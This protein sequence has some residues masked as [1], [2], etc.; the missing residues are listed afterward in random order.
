[1]AKKSFQIELPDAERR[2][3]G[4]HIEQDF[5]LAKASHLEWSERCATFM[6]KWEAR[7]EKTKAGDEGKPNHRVPLVQ[8]QCFN[9]WAR[10]AQALL[11]DDAEVTAEGTTPTDRAQCVKIGRY[12]T[13]RLFSQ[14]KIIN[15]LLEF[16]FR[17]LLN[18][19]SAAYRPWYRHTFDTIENGKRVEAC[20]YEGPGFFPLEPD[21]L[22][23]PPERGVRSLQDFSFVIRRYPATVDEIIRGDGTLYQGTSEPE[24]AQKLVDWA[25]NNTSNDYTLAGMDP[26]RAEREKSE[27]VDY[28]AYMLSRRT[29]WVWEW[30]GKWRPLKGTADAGIDDLKGREVLESD[31]VVRYIPGLNEVVGVQD[32]L[33]LYPKMARRR[34]FVESTL[35]KDGTYRGKGFGALLGDLEDDLTANSRLFTAAGELSVWPIV[36]FKPGAG[37]KPGMFQLEPGMAIPTEDPQGVNVVRITPNLE[38]AQARQQDIVAQGER[39]TGITDQS[40][41]RAIDQP[42][43]P[44]TAAGQLALIE[45]G[46]V[47]AYL[48]ATVL[49]EDAEL[50]IGD[51][52]D[53]DCDL[54]PKTEP[55]L[56]FR[57]TKEQANGLFDVKQGGSFMTAKEFGGRYDFR[58]KFAVT[59][60]QRD[61]QKQ[62]FVTFYGACM[63]N[64][65]C[66]QNPRALWVLMNM[67]AQKFNIDFQDIVPK[68]ADLD[69]TYTPEEE[70]ARMLEGQTV[71][72]NPGDD[73]RKHI[74]EHGAEIEQERRDPDRDERAIALGIEHILK[75]RDQL[76]FKQW[77]QIQTQALAQSMQPQQPGPGQFSPEQMQHLALMAHAQQGQ[78]GAGGVP[79][80]A[81][82]GGGLASQMEPAA[83]PGMIP[84][85]PQGIGAPVG[86]GLPA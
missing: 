18:G 63:Q 10:D 39:V 56:F 13:N 34:P 53:L 14:M 24:F 9:K 3:I 68:P 50:I 65:I 27:G 15:P 55:G 4:D 20:D 2:R 86:N 25:R 32:L 8:W 59:V 69:R 33:E 84:L 51:V 72:V 70:W 26:V 41:G 42:N 44:R 66:A 45:E 71:P 78:P 74:D 40:L 49:R 83:A 77:A 35:I 37:M 11:G 43:A 48:D 75:H 1:M 6:K 12:M 23:I 30:Y 17:R 80:Q 79:G 7:I 60:W 38:F 54:A 22:I 19:W 16:L 76:Q 36:F 29:I 28:D 81:P 64:P 58:L 61:K 21:D 5:L 46:N 62:E 85:P 67:L 82:M 31:W 73:D 47:R 57:V 52:W